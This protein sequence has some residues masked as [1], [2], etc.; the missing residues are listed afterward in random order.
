MHPYSFRHENLFTACDA[1]EM[2]PEKEKLDRERAEKERIDRERLEKEKQ[3]AEKLLKEKEE[4]ARKE[5]EKKALEEKMRKQ[6]EK[7]KK[8]REEA[9]RCDPVPFPLPI[10]K[11]CLPENSRISLKLVCTR[12][13]YKMTTSTWTLASPITTW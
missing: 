2:S 12:S 8:E 3:D 11:L 4:R 5:K 1:G 6:R 10:S 9:L 7:E 13:F